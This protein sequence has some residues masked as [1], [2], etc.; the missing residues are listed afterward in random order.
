MSRATILGVNG[1]EDVEKRL[2]QN[3]HI[4]NSESI[5]S[6]N[7]PN[8][9]LESGN[10]ICH[11]LHKLKLDDSL[12]LTIFFKQC[13]VLCSIKSFSTCN[14]T[15]MPFYACTFFSLLIS[16]ILHRTLDNEKNTHILFSCVVQNQHQ[17][18]NSVTK[19][20]EHYSLTIPIE[21]LKF[22]LSEEKNILASK[23]VGE[24]LHSWKMFEDFKEI[25]KRI[26]DV[27]HINEILINNN[28]KLPILHKL[29]SFKGIL[30]TGSSGS[31]KTV[32]L[33][34]IEH[35]LKLPKPGRKYKTAR[36]SSVE[37]L[38]K[39]FGESER[40]LRNILR[41][42]KNEKEAGKPLEINVF[43]IDELD[44]LFPV[45]TRETDSSGIDLGHRLTTTLLSELDGIGDE[46]NIFVI[47]AVVDPKSIHSSL[48]RP[49]RFDVK[50]DLDKQI[51]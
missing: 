17:L 31:G 8:S 28:N 50:I 20:F 46:K 33:R 5:V 38:S 36:I 7:V 9:L 16:L 24:D 32:L 34:E 3:F 44:A 21:I 23:T 26:E 15:E 49:G 6:I 45:K 48:L 19:L 40:R 10:G 11:S 13:D 30:I 43:F 22:G 47:G 25:T 37:V 18:K 2:T 41:R 35:Y 29:S 51:P 12:N 4:S 14:F 39:Y 27:F 1:E 42:K